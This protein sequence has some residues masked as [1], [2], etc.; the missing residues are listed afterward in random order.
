MKR[1]DESGIALI[2]TLMV[3]MLLA[4]LMAGFFAAV[5]ADTRSN[6]LDKDQT[7]AYAAA[8]AGLEKLTSDLAALFNGDVSPSTAQINALAA[9]PPSIPGFE[10]RAPGGSPGS[11]YA[12]TWAC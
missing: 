3:M 8:H 11:G 4:A 12:V 1:K 5:N 6:A 10:F 2:V 7:R 9:T